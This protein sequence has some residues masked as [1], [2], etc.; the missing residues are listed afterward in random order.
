M[1]TSPPGTTG[2]RGPT[3]PISQQDRT[4]TDPT[5]RAVTNPEGVRARRVAGHLGAEI[6]GVSL[7]DLSDPVLAG[8]QAALLE[9][10]VL[11]VRDQDLDHAGHVA[12]ARRWGEITRRPPPHRGVFPEGFPEILTVDPQAEHDLFGLDFEG[13]YRG[14]WTSCDA[15]WHTDLTPA[16][17]PPSV[18]IL[19]AEAV[20]SF[21]G[22]TQWASLTA[23]Y[24]GLSAPLQDLACELRAEHAFF[25]GC[26]MI[27][28]DDLDARVLAVNREHP[29]AAIHP[30][31]RVI[32]E[33]GKRALFVNPASVSRI[34]GVAT[35]ESRHLL[36]LFFEEAT[37]PEYTV[38]HQWRV[39]DVAIWDNRVTA[40][41]SPGD[42]PAGERRRLHRVTIMGDRPVGPDGFTSE[43]VAG[44]PFY[45]L[46]PEGE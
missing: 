13:H 21:G 45:P 46:S 36:G 27:A 29:L 26:Q 8:L 33:T 4:G 20:P 12:F 11:F 35:A 5:P 14:R 38:R 34:M 24:D 15:G 19:R 41:L 2:H 17:N 18:S 6:G 25:A 37:R 22:D 16:V 10:Q 42:A 32:P 44:D 43:A 30:V 39:G 9:H 31:V 3:T 40:H 23:A 1:T 7:S 28:H